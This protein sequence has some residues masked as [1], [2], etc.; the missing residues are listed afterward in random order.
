MC[1]LNI[2]ICFSVNCLFL[3]FAHFLLGC[4]YYWFVTFSLYIIDTV[5]FS[6]IYIVL[7]FLLV[8]HLSFAFIIVFHNSEIKKFKLLSFFLFKKCCYNHN[9][10]AVDIHMY[11]FSH[12]INPIFK[13]S[14]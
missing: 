12:I 3:L 5:P 9:M 11:V 8:Y 14:F 4:F 2:F 6:F 13:K 1:S 10:H 7:Y